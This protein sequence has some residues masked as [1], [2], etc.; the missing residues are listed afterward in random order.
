VQSTAAPTNNSP[1]AAPTYSAKFDGNG[2][3]SPVWVEDF[4]D[5]KKFDNGVGGGLDQDT[6]PYPR[7]G[8]AYDVNGGSNKF[9]PAVLAQR[10]HQ[11]K[12]DPQPYYNDWE[13]P[14]SNPTGY[15]GEHFRPNQ[16]WETNG[17]KS[18]WNLHQA[19]PQPFYA[20]WEQPYSN[21][22]GYV[23]RVDPVFRP[24]Q[25][26]AYNGGQSGWNLH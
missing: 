16:P 18:G 25:P 9:G 23:S 26:W 21:P 4:T 17:H 8:S 1:Y 22:S 2:Q 6:H 12:G 15:D 19:D 11:T 13:Q 10:R 20:G 3:Y 24:D 14:Y 7:S 5:S